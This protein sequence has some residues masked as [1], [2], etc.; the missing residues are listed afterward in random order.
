MWNKY[1]G[2]SGASAC[3]L[4]MAS[5]EAE[6]GGLEGSPSPSS[7]TDP[8]LP[9]AGGGVTV[10]ITSCALEPLVAESEDS[11]Q[12]FSTKTVFMNRFATKKGLSTASL[13]VLTSGEH[14]DEL[15][16]EDLSDGGSEQ[17]KEGSTGSIP[18][19]QSLEGEVRL[20]DCRGK[21]MGGGEEGLVMRGGEK[22]EGVIPDGEEQ[23]G[24]VQGSGANTS[25][26]AVTGQG[27]CPGEV[28]GL[29]RQPEKCPD[30]LGR[31]PNPPKT[32]VEGNSFLWCC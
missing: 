30:E 24:L 23:G 16:L 29:E 32:A 7:S 11:L 18:D 1:R 28:L 26:G 6:E 27:K 3:T 14:L 15:S 25:V 2:S 17:D 19:C 9:D 21:A 12:P 10:L 4:I 8:G 13:D 20:E 31:P 22:E 5:T